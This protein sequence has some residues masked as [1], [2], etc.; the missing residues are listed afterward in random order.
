MPNFSKNTLNKLK[1]GDLGRGIELEI[2]PKSAGGINPGDVLIFNYKLGRA[3]GERTVLVVRPVEK[4]AKTGNSLLTCVKVDLPAQI[5]PNYIDNLYNERSSLG[6]NQYRT[7]IMQ[8]IIGN[9]RRIT[10]YDPIDDLEED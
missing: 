7:Y 9:L 8:N 3:T 4:D 5:S 6:S 2:V 10:S 1:Y